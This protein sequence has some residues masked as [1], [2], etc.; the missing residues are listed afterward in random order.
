MKPAFLSL[1]VI[2]IA[3]LGRVSIAAAEV[4]APPVTNGLWLYL[5]AAREPSARTAAGLPPVANGR[6]MERWL[7]GDGG[8]VSVVQ[9]WAAGRP[10]YR[11][12]ETE[13]FVR[14]DGKD[15]YLSLTGSRHR[16]QAVTAFVLAA[17]RSNRGGF[18][19]V[20]GAGE[21]GRNDY[22][23]GLNLDQGPTPSS[24]LSVLN[25]E[26]AGAGGFRNFLQPGR[27][28]AAGLP[29][30]SFHVFT[31]R[32]Q[33]GPKG[34]EL[35]LDSNKLGDRPRTESVL[36]LDELVIG[37]RLYSNDPGGAAGGAG[38]LS[39]GHRRRAVL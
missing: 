7:S 21:I 16:V 22:T 39:R 27:N 20:F 15:D 32:S 6:P 11:N 4:V 13:A 2:S 1:L 36:G 14:F 24:D 37:G 23:S 25:V 19:G 17:P 28:L 9:P 29:F 35:F 26:S 38:Q 30:D 18:S 3:E 8:G 34:N 10:V 12:D 5:D 33:V 31:V